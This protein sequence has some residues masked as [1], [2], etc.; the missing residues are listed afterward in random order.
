MKNP[1]TLELKIESIEKLIREGEF[2]GARVHLREIPV[3]SVPRDSLV[4]FANLANRSQEFDL[5]L[6][7]LH[8][9]VRGDPRLVGNPT[10]LEKMEYAFVLRK[11]GAVGEAL[12][13]AESVNANSHPKALYH[14]ASC[15]ISMWDYLTAVPL[16]KE[17]IGLLPVDDYHR[18]VAMMNLVAAL[19]QCDQ[20]HEAELLLGELQET[21]KQQSLKLLLGNSFELKAQL[22]LR[23]KNWALA[24]E[25]A[26]KSLELLPQSRT[27][28]GLFARKWEA[29]VE[30]LETGKTAPITRVKKLATELSHWETVR[31]CDFHKAVAKQNQK[32]LRYLYY[33]TPFPSYRDKI[34]Q[35][36]ESGLDLPDLVFW[37]GSQLK[38][39][40]LLIHLMEARCGDR[41][42]SP[43]K[44]LHRLLI[45]L[46]RDF[47][48]PL[49]PVTAFGLIFPDEY[50]SPT[51]LNRIHQLVKKLRGW[52]EKS[53]AAISIETVGSS[54]R[55]K[56]ESPSC[57]AV[58]R[59]PMD[60]SPK[61]LEF[62]KVQSIFSGRTTSASE[63]RENL[64]LS[65]G[66][67]NG[68]LNWAVENN[69][70]EKSGNGRMTRYKFSA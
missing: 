51:A 26:Q 44:A 54:Y 21:L 46:C 45:A 57:I 53:D 11:V 31:E 67:V 33:G 4:R 2:T 37:N 65:F 52:L 8:R 59:L 3:T 5:S 25:S 40:K 61:E 50:Y 30:C 16:L 24:R 36:S 15:R 41:E 49:N 48:K 22:H 12:S 1:N 66:K 35:R 32:R 69:R 18:Q 55:L 9:I 34:L 64:N 6:R 42:L 63:V 47:Y 68:L 28:S 60:M 23:Q 17:Y 7:A 27:T 13:L 38:K 62:Q 14:I 58:P 19:I 43:G 29:I 39:E 20:L 10:D 70:V 56:F